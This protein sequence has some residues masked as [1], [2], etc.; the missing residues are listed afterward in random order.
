ML[1]SFFYWF[2]FAMYTFHGFS[3]QP[4]S[5]LQHKT[6]VQEGDADG[7]ALFPPAA[8]SAH[9]CLHLLST[10]SPGRQ[11]G[12]H[13]H[14]LVHTSQ[15]MWR[16]KQYWSLSLWSCW[17]ISFVHRLSAAPDARTPW[18]AAAAPRPVIHRSCTGPGS[19]TTDIHSNVFNVLTTLKW[20]RF[21]VTE[22]LPDMFFTPNVTC[23]SI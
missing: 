20:I 21:F 18:R 9:W 10:F 6:P 4:G 2:N 3:N 5:R 19:D 14:L 15:Y 22:L 1:H 12:Q 17:V 13:E 11:S 23:N 8:V 7:K 16:F